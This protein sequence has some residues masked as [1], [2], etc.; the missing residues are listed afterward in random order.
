MLSIGATP[1]FVCRQTGTS[2]KMIE[3]HYGQVN[4]LA[5]ELDTMIASAAAKTRNPAGTLEEDVSSGESGKEEE[6]QIDQQLTERAGERVRT[7]DVQLG[8]LAFYH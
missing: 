8:K 4:V 1:L 5:R 6:A 2:L 7:A 3:E